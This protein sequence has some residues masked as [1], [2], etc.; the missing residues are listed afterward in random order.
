MNKSKSQKIILIT[1][2]AQGLGREIA[3]W[4]A[5]KGEKVIVLDKTSKEQIELSF[6]ENIYSYNSADITDTEKTDALIEKIISEAGR[7]DV[8]I[9]NAAIKIF[10]ELEA[11]NVNNIEQAIKTNITALI[12]M[13]KR[14]LPVFVR[15]GYGDVI[16]ISS[17]AAFNG[18]KKGSVYC[19]T[20][21]AV[22][23]FTQAIAKE[24]TGENIKINCICPQNIATPENLGKSYLD[25]N[26]LIPTEK[27]IKAI[28]KVLRSK[29]SGR[30][31]PVISRRT[32][33]KN[34]LEDF[35]RC[36]FWLRGDV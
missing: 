18:Y 17:N 23:L 8:L 3:L 7:I 1:G 9:N 28:E 34:I 16:N 25:K 6:L 4:Y 12:L 30:L 24:F 20:K 27:V 29:C 19:A 33:L 5:K 26:K 32:L 13:T 31:I 21:S 11:L 10:G 36:F 2:A 35:K 14:V 15:Q 22:N